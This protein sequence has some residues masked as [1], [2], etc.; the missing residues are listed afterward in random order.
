MKKRLLAG[1]LTG[2]VLLGLILA[3]LAL[4]ILLPGSFEMAQENEPS[5]ERD[6]VDFGGTYDTG[7]RTLRG[8]QVMTLTNR[9]GEDL[10]QIVLRAD[11]NGESADAVAVSDLKIDGQSVNYAFDEDDPT[12]LRMDYAWG[13]EE[14]IELSFLA[15]IKT[16]KADGAAI[17]SLPKLAAYEDG[18]WRTDMYD[19]LA[20]YSGGPAFD[21]QVKYLIVYDGMSAAFGGELTFAGY[22]NS[23]VYA[24][25][26]QGARDVTFAL[27]EGYELRKTVDGIKVTVLAEDYGTGQKLFARTQEALRSLSAIGL[28]YPFP[29]LSV[30]QSDTGKE[31]GEIGSGVIALSAEEDKETLRRQ[32]T[33]LIAR[34]TFGVLV[35]NDAYNE[36][37]LSHS[38]ASAAE[39]MAYRRLKGE[40]AYETRFF[41]EIEIAARVTRPFGVNVGAGVSAFGGDWE[42]TQLLRDQGA[43]M[44]LGIE[45]AVGEEAFLQALKQYAQEN[46]GQIASRADFESVLCEATGSDWSG[47]L[48]DELSF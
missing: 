23:P 18:A 20:G 46:A 34:Q 11:M 40:N 38:L 24:A 21:Y 9:T 32:L 30:V 1:C 48:T 7:T 25:Q 4:H 37:W 17:V 6:F 8:T 28:A 29:S 12:V 41:D 43:A 10:S 45:Q 31:D 16:P 33:R 26:M 47:Y 44:L 35:G 15:M 27:L 42:M 19:A 5:P 39:L 36:P 14:K 2:I 22:D 13:A 3:A